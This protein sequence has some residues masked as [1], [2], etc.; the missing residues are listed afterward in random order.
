MGNW[1]VKGSITGISLKMCLKLFN[2]HS[3]WHPATWK[4]RGMCGCD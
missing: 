3:L 2:H 1:T 4:S